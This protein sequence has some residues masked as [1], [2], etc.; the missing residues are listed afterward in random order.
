MPLSFAQLTKPFTEDEAATDL[1]ALLEK[2]GFKATS[3]QE[4]S[5]P[6]S[7]V[8]LGAHLFAKA[9]EFWGG[10][11]EQGYIDTAEEEGLTRLSSSHY[12]NTRHAAVPTQ[13]RE[14]FTTA[15]GEGPHSINV[16][17]IVVTDDEGHTFRNVQGLGIVYPVSLTSAAPVTLLCEAEIADADHNVADDVVTQLVTTYAGVSCT[18]DADPDTGSSI[19]QL[20]ADQESDVA[21]E[22]RDATKW[23]TLAIESVRD[24]LKNVALNAASGIAKVEVDDGNPRGAGTANVY[25]AGAAAVAGGSDVTATQS[26]LDARFFGNT[27]TPPRVQAIAA[28]SL[29]LTIVGTVY[30]DSNYSASDV[31]AAVEASLLEF[32]EATPLGGWDYS[33]GPANVVRVND[34][35]DAIRTSLISGSKPVKTVTITTPAGDLAVGSFQLVVPPGS[36]SLTYTPV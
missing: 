11:A 34:I 15:S 28:T 19:I 31:Q 18:N 14:T 33:P 6:F 2:L 22:T 36:Y 20:G 4:G 10:I 7:L 27:G 35:E 23:P 24:A 30:Y 26:A 3:W 21:L 25:I 9:S 16:G 32:I 1:I 29:T 13:I 12:Q 5:V 17:N 8:M